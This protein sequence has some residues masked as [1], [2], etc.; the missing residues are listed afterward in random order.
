MP[1]SPFSVKQ[2]RIFFIS[3]WLTLMLDQAVVLY[4]FGL[5]WHEAAIDSAISN[6]LLLLICLVMM[7]TYRY[8]LPR[9]ERFL[10]LFGVCLIFST[11][12]LLLCKWLLNMLV[13]FYATSPDTLYR[14]LPIRAS[15]ALLILGCVSMVSALWYNTAEQ[16]ENELRKADAEKLTKE[17]ELF[18]LRQQLQPHFLFNSLNSINALIGIRPDEARKMV[19]QLSDFLRGT[20]RKEGNQSIPFS[21]ELEYLKLYLE[22]EKVRFGYRLKTE[23]DVSDDSLTWKI[24]TLLLQPLMENAIKFGLYGTTGEVVIGLRAKIADKHLV[25]AIMNPFDPDMQM[26]P[27]TGFGLESV[28]RRLYL[29]FGRN[30]LV[31]INKTQ[32]SFVVIFRIPDTHA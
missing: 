29:L 14:S 17:A 22:I 26:P 20:I 11:V 27:G 19:Q 4:W 28:K 16:K 18:K 8:Y 31:E 9:R 21:E 6:G 2:F 13:N 10:N 25:V 7:N 5:P 32:N 30:D 1:A 24:P 15:M 12:W 3:C 23:I